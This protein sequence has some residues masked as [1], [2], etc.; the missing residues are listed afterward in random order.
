M[1]RFRTRTRLAT[2]GEPLDVCTT[3]LGDGYSFRLTVD[4]LARHVSIQPVHPGHKCQIR[5]FAGMCGQPA[6]WELRYWQAL[7]TLREP[8]PTNQ[9]TE[10]LF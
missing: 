10:P 4:A 8:I 1:S 7:E 6:S 5:T 9:P 3:H 2:L